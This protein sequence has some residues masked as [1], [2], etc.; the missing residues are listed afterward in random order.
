MW[1]RCKIGFVIKVLAT[2]LMWRQVTARIV[3]GKSA[4]KLSRDT[5][6]AISMP[7]PKMTPIQTDVIPSGLPVRWI[8]EGPKLRGNFTLVIS[9]SRR[10]ASSTPSLLQPVSHST[11]YVEYLES[12]T[13]TVLTLPENRDGLQI[14][15]TL[16]DKNQNRAREAQNSIR[17][18]PC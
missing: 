10:N 7:T 18:Y 1:A 11:L 14:T 8:Y 3:S 12:L 17:L 5:L 9:V 6:S 13:D 2:V 15:A 4:T 16:R